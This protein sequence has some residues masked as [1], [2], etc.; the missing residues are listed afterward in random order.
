MTKFGRGLEALIPKKTEQGSGEAEHK[1]EA[2]FSIDIEKIKPNPYQPRRDFDEQALKALADSIRSHGI[3]QPLLVSRVENPDVGTTEYHLIAGERRWRAAKMAGFSRVPVII[4]ESTDR[5]KLEL[6]LIENAQREDLNPIEKALAFKRLHEEFGFSHSDI[7]SL[8]GKSRVAVVNTM[9][10][11]TLPEDIKQAIREGKISEGH[12]RGILMARGEEQQRI[13]FVQIIEK[14]L[15]AREAEDSA[16]KLSGWQPK[17]RTKE[18]IAEFKGLEEELKRILEW[19]LLK[20]RMEAGFPK[21]VIS[22]NSKKDLEGLIKKL[23]P[24]P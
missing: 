3:L 15:T 22:F 12:A 24:K 17:K 4:R 9:R 6:S 5:Q 20:I 14:G 1:K 21:L 2:V 18:F 8:V 19:P 7:G 11:L 13:V 23:N 16:R 10:L